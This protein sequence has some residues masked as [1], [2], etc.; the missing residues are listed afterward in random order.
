MP[1]RALRAFSGRFC[2][3]SVKEGSD[4]RVEI[5]FEHEDVEA[6]ANDSQTSINED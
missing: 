1:G 2:N 6:E 5:N 3:L 4:E